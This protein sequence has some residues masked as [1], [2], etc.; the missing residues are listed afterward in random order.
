MPHSPQEHSRARILVA[1]SALVVAMI[2][3]QAGAALSKQLFPQVGTGGGDGPAAVFAT[4]ILLGGVAALAAL[5]AA[6]ERGA[7]CSSMAQC[8]AP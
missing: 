8:W 3:V 6:G 5:A 1:L 2:S 4:L 7:P